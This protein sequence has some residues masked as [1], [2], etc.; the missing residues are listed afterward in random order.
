MQRLGTGAVDSPPSTGPHNLKLHSASVHIWP[1]VDADRQWIKIWGKER[2]RRPALAVIGNLQRG[3]GLVEWKGGAK[4]EM[5]VTRASEEICLSRNIGILDCLTEE[6]VSLL[7]PFS[8]ALAVRME[9]LVYGIF[10]PGTTGVLKMVERRNEESNRSV[11]VVALALVCKMLKT[12]KTPSPCEK[13]SCEKC[14]SFLKM[15]STIDG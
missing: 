5:C 6:S 9:V 2:W 15:H 13:F 8:H 12:K 1:A 3:L 7:C 10:R 11:F 4:Y 14:L